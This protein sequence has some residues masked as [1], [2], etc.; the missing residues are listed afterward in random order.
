[1]KVSMKIDHELDQISKLAPAVV[2]VLDQLCKIASAFGRFL[3]RMAPVFV[4]VFALLALLR[5][6]WQHMWR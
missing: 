5:Q 6:L 1:M 2:R 3:K 4:E